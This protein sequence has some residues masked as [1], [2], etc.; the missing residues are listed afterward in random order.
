MKKIFS[1]VVLALVMS[2]VLT[3]CASKKAKSAKGPKTYRIDLGSAM[4]TIELGEEKKVI[5]VSSLLPEG[6][7]PVTGE[8][9]SVMWSFVSDEDIG[10]VYVSCGDNSEDYVLIEDVVAGNA[11]Y[12]S[13]SIPIDLDVAGPLYINLWS[14]TT[15]VCEVAYIDAK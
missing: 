4:S 5:N 12:A 7:T 9:V 2:L 11:V 1:F 13:K 15:A 14:D 10:T 8:K 3:G 6:T